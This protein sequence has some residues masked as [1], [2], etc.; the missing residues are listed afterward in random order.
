MN[1]YDVDPKK[2][3]LRKLRVYNSNLAD[4]DSPKERMALNYDE[5][6]EVIKE[7]KLDN[8]YYI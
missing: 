6:E 5:H 3:V 1:C 4:Y 8:C 2:D 7:R